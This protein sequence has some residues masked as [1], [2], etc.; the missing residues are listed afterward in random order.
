MFHSFFQTGKSHF[1]ADFQDQEGVR[2][3]HK[4]TLCNPNDGILKKKFIAITR[5]Y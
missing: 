4:C 1:T 5:F 3:M 2:I